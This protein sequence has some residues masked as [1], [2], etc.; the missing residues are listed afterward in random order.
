MSRRL[1]R[2]ALLVATAVLAAAC[3]GPSTPAL[4]DPVEIL[5]GS[6]EAMQSVKTVHV[7]V[8]VSG[9]I[10][11]DLTGTGG[12]ELPLDGTSL[13][14][15]IDVERPAARA[16]FSVPAFL[17]LAG[18]LIAVDDTAYVKTSLTG[19]LFQKMTLGDAGLPTDPGSMGDLDLAELRTLLAKPEVAPT[20]GDDV[21]CGSRDCYTVT[22]DLTAAEIAALSDANISD[23]GLPIDVG[24]DFG[25]SVT[26]DVEKDGLRLARVSLAVEAGTAGSV[27][28]DITLSKWDEPVTVTAPPA[29][30]V[31]PGS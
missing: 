10:E 2:V 3:G 6:I 13:T 31:Q 29:N 21:Q 12:S 15:D 9:T 27:R 1:P 18:E 30:Q 23:L 16:T 22:I 14:A 17:G 5:V 26:F 25:F 28:I 19:A 7:D 20:K 24:D 4:T 11:A 8:A